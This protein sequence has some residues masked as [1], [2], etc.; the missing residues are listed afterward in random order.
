LKELS[1]DVHVDDIRPELTEL[2]TVFRS[3]M[4]WSD[5]GATPQIERSGMDGSHRQVLVDTHLKWP[6][7]ITLD[8]EEKRLYWA[9]AKL[10]T[11]A[12]CRF[13][14]S[15]RRVV[16]SSRETVGHPF[17]VS[18]FEDWIY[19]SDWH[20]KSIMKANKFN[21]KAPAAITSRNSVAAPFISLSLSSAF[22]DF[23]RRNLL[24]L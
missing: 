10:N 12:S 5:W 15:E 16:L 23:S 6:N 24:F 13:D 22:Y 7:G 4:Y 9:D 14:G 17:S 8:Y 3:W 20:H 1:N 21:G 18:V 11:I 19:W 2:I